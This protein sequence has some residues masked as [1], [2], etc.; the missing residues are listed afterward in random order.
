MS[1]RFSLFFIF[2]LPAF[3]ATS[4]LNGTYTAGQLG[5]DFP[6]I[7]DAITEIQAGVSGPV[8]I[9]VSDGQYGALNLSNFQPLSGDSLVIRSASGNPQLVRF[10]GGNFMHVNN[11]TL[12]DIGF[13]KSVSNNLTL[14]KITECYILKFSGCR[15][16]DGLTALYTPDESTVIIQHAN[17]TPY[18]RVFFDSCYI[19]SLDGQNPQNYNYTMKEVGEMGRTYFHA[20]TILGGWKCWSSYY[21]AFSDCYLVTDEGLQEPGNAFFDHCELHFNTTSGAY[22]GLTAEIINDSEVYSQIPINLIFDSLMNS[23]FYA[24]IEMSHNQGADAFNNRF[25]ERFNLSFGYSILFKDNIFYAN[26]YLWDSP[27]L[28]N[29]FFLDTLYT[30]GA[31]YHNN[32][33]PNS[34]LS[35]SGS[36]IQ[37]NN[38]H[39]FQC[40]VPNVGLLGNNFS[41]DDAETLNYAFFDS[42]PTFYD[43]EYIGTIDLHIQNPALFSQGIEVTF[44][45]EQDI[46]GEIRSQNP[47]IGADEACMQLPLRD[48]LFLQ[49]GT[50]YALKSCASLSG[51][52][53]KPASV[54]GGTPAQPTV[55]VDALK[56]VWLEDALGNIVD[57][58]YLSPTLAIGSGKRTY[59]IGCGAW[60]YYST[61]VPAGGVLTWE[62][63]SAVSDPL[64]N[65]VIIT[66]QDDLEVIAIVDLGACGVKHDTLVFVVDQQIQAWIMMDSMICRTFYFHPYV[67]CYDS[68]LWTFSDGTSSTDPFLTFHTF[69]TAGVQQISLTAWN[70]GF[71]SFFS[72]ELPMSCVGLDE[73]DAKYFQVYPNPVNDFLN[74]EWMNGDASAAYFILDQSGRIIKSGRLDNYSAV[75]VGMLSQGLYFLSIGGRQELFVKR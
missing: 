15:I 44:L 45:A 57:S 39:R 22:P 13:Y 59:E 71:S 23:T 31:L 66:P 48:T 27:T 53:W 20:D 36:M 68:L 75:D 55:Y 28:V 18:T 46:D 62:P 9:V 49:C 61:Y 24:P 43:P 7:Q 3:W 26:S 5:D 37:Q 1:I 4:Q 11:V 65:H 56:L 73:L 12:Q 21:R 14:L 34:F 54:I 63:E 74:V 17:E 64:S 40:S 8:T 38:I 29:N 6:D 58:M 30:A 67:L 19:S 33:G 50:T 51:L 25:H 32:F 69:P 52:Q 41:A 72:Q 60:G 70:N 47:S 2:F 10:T 35:Y 16:E 42:N